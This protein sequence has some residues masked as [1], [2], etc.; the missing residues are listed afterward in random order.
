MN[1]ACIA[2]VLY[3]YFCVSASGFCFRHGRN[4]FGT[5]SR[6][7]RCFARPPKVRHILATWEFVFNLNFWDQSKRDETHNKTHIQKT[8]PTKKTHKKH[9]LLSTNEMSNHIDRPLR[10]SPPVTHSA[11]PRRIRIPT[12]A[13]APAAPLGAHTI[14]V[15]PHAHCC[16]CEQR[17]PEEKPRENWVHTLTP[18]RNKLRETRAEWG[19][20]GYSLSPSESE[21]G[22]W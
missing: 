11:H 1:D 10:H 3:A 20:R 18:T 6:K 15:R 8:L 5:V 19:G 4:K 16:R 21:C 9:S 2:A 12:L 7:V 13:A 17:A 14:S 22:G